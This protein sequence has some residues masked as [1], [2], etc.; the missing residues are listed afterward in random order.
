[1][2]TK[3]R[4][5]MLLDVSK[6]MGCR[7]C[8][9]ACKQWN[10]LPA[11]ETKFEGT[12]QNPPKLS[13]NTLTLITF[14]EIDGKTP[15]GPP[16]WLFRKEQCHHCGEAACLQVCPTGAIKRSKNGIVFI[17]QGI[18]AGC[19]YCVETCPFH[20]PQAN[21]KTGTA[22][23]C[24]MCMDRVSGGL[25]PACATACPTGAVKFG[26]R[27]EMVSI[28]SQRVTELKA[29][30]FADARA[31]GASD[32][33]L[34]GLGAMYVLTD[35]ASVFGLPEKPTL[36]TR[37]IISKWLLGVIPGLAIVFAMWKRLQKDD[38]AQAKTGGE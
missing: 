1:M 6:C 30:G 26:P 11:E 3:A 21:Q 31:Y 36:P 8:Q 28:A 15:G 37:K 32:D 5:G 20:V 33:E 19:K 22:K 14:K 17:D 9:V 10:Q 29:E 35:K 27:D 13:G 16:R 34:G 23:K 4:I 7:G 18:C 2:A 38:T 24:W 12:Y 25:K